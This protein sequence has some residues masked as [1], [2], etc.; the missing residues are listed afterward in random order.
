MSS[1]PSR[2]AQGT[3]GYADFSQA[4]QLG[5]AK[6]KVGGAFVAPTAEGAAKVVEE[7]PKEEG[8][9]E[10]D[11]AIKIKRDTTDRGRLPA[12]PGLVHRSCARSTT[13]PRSATWSRRS[14]A[15]IASEDGQK[16]AADAAGSAP[17]SDK[18]R[19]EVEATLDTIGNGS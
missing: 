18:L 3:I 1:R 13:T 19:T 6:I 15:Y 17:I 10:H 7:S 11:L 8:V 16:A 9:P 4:G 5:V 12:D 2:A 14:S